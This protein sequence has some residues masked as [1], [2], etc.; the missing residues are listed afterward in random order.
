M[1]YSFRVSCF[2]KKYLATLWWLKI[3]VLEPNVQQNVVLSDCAFCYVMH[4]FVLFCVCF[5]P[6]KMR[7]CCGQKSLL[8]VVLQLFFLSD[9]CFHVMIRKV[10]F[11]KKNCLLS[12]HDRAFLES[13]VMRMIFQEKDKKKVKLWAKMYKI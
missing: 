13:K 4:I 3:A 11:S 2:Q 5:C 10:F 12:F 7:Q 6:E 1:S 9:S 8:L